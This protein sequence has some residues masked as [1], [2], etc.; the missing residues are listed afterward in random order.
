M[1]EAAELACLALATEMPRVALLRDR[2]EEGLR[3]RFPGVS[4]HG[5]SASRLPNTSNFSL[6][7]FEAEGVLAVLDRL[8]VACSIGSACS[9]QPD[10]SHVLRAMGVSD[11]LAR[12]SLRFSFSRQNTEEE[13]NFALDALVQA[14]DRLRPFAAGD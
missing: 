10:A 8:G 3:Q 9:G 4:F 14:G 13:L 11:D 12:S 1:G 6:P 5:G 7:G 2:F